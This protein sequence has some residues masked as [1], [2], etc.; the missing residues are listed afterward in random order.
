MKPS[1]HTPS[2]ERIWSAFEWQQECN[3]LTAEMA[4]PER[5]RM[6][7]F[8]TYCAMQRRAATRHGQHDAAEYIG[9]IVDDLDA[10]LPGKVS[11]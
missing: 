8:H 2:G 1:T 3:F 7:G 5:E 11:V 6:A 9:H 10:Q 4:K